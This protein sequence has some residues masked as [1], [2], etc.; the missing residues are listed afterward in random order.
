MKG[1]RGETA[2]DCTAILAHMTNLDRSLTGRT[3]WAGLDKEVR[4]QSANSDQMRF[5]LASNGIFPTVN[6][7]L[8]RPQH[9]N[10]CSRIF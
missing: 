5:R 8:Q 6:I 1:H 10:V 4:A 7:A 9:Q 3:L 2:F